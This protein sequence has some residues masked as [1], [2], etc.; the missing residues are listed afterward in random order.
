[1]NRQQSRDSD[2]SFHESYPIYG[3]NDPHHGP[4][5]TSPYDSSNNQGPYSHKD[6]QW[7]H[8]YSD[9]RQSNRQQPHP[10]DRKEAELNNIQ[11]QH[12]SQHSSQHQSQSSQSFN[13]HQQTTL[14]QHG[15][16]TTFVE[17]TPTPGTDSRDTITNSHNYYHPQHSNIR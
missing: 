16:E 13:Q 1:M 6:R 5:G 2:D 17:S 11:S 15:S 4:Y 7:G 3:I 8:A 14:Q 9:R 12:S 10:F